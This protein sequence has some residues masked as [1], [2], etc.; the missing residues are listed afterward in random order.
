M[1]DLQATDGKEKVKETTPENVVLP[2]VDTLAEEFMTFLLALSFGA[3]RIKELL[4]NPNNFALIWFQLCDEFKLELTILIVIGLNSGNKLDK[5][6]LVALD[7][8]DKSKIPTIDPL[9]NSDP[10]VVLKSS[11][12]DL[13][14]HV[15]N[16]RHLRIRDHFDLSPVDTL[17][18][19]NEGQHMRHVVSLDIDAAR[20]LVA[21]EY[22]E[23][24]ERFLLI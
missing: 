3:T 14:A 9:L 1:I 23:D 16:L 24:H 6:L 13:V 20:S 22:R 17:N 11:L 15:Q 4:R 5:S 2:I 18:P 12:A 10:R 7:T 19:M 21:V 8:L